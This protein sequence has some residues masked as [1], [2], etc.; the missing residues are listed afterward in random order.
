MKKIA[1]VVSGWHFPLSFYRGMANQKLPEGWSM[2]LFCVSHRNPEIADIEKDGQTF[3]DDI[4]GVLDKKLYDKIATK[5]DLYKLGWHYYELPNTIGDWG[6]TNQWFD[7]LKDKAKEYDLYLFSHDDNLVIHDRVIADQIED[8]NYKKWGIL[9]NSPGT[10]W[11]HLRGSFEF[12]KPKVLEKL[13]WK[14]DMGLV[15]LNREGQ[16]NT[17]GDLI[18]LNDWNN[19]V[20]PL[21]DFVKKNKVKI[22]FLSPCYRVSAYVIE[23]ERGYIS[24]TH[25]TNTKYEDAG[26]NYLKDN[27]II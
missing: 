25:G 12:F 11:G 26:L 14:F 16:F 17:T 7:L 8:P 2:D 27:G 21:M 20:P 9:T 6:N 10:P 15:T 19:T 23:G 22:A 13:G 1:V 24:K 3:A 18:E 4:R 5:V